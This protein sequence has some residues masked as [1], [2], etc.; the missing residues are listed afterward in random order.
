MRNLSNIR[1]WCTQYDSMFKVNTVVCAQNW[2]ED[3]NDHIAALDPIRWKI[4]QCQLLEGENTGKGALRDGKN[5]LVTDSQFTSFIQKHEDKHG[6]IMK[7]EDNETML[8]SYIMIDE[9]GYFLDCEGGKKERS[10]HSV[11]DVGVDEAFKGVC[12]MPAMF[13]KRDGKFA[14]NKEQLLQEKQ[15]KETENENHHQ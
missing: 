2:E 9:Q 13:E 7:P 8:N 15:K 10:K 6:E 1:E 14:W 11:F 3:M 4:F 12:F 5:S